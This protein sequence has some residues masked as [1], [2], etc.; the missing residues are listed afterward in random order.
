SHFRHNIEL[1]T[2]QPKYIKTICG[3]GYN[4]EIVKS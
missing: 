4:M 3:F 2:K 1:V